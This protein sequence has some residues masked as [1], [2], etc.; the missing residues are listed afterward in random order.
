VF[1]ET[2]FQISC[3]ETPSAQIIVSHDQHKTH[4]QCARTQISYEA[5]NTLYIFNLSMDIK[6]LKVEGK[7]LKSPSMVGTHS[8]SG[9]KES[10]RV[11]RKEKFRL[12]LF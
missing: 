8:W 1:L 11:P 4:Y 5:E 9:I 3:K 7:T 12:S 6:S 2:N 10:T